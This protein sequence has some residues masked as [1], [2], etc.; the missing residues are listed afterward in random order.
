MK[1]VLAGL[2]AL[3]V[4]AV[5]A[6]TFAL[7]EVEDASAQAAFVLNSGR[8]GLTCTLSGSYSGSGHATFVLNNGGQILFSC[9]GSY[10]EAPPPSAVV[11]SATGPF[12][13]AC[14][15]V[16]DPAGGFHASCHN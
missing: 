8:D 2:L 7:V 9:N 11:T 16:I 5:A 3:S 13:T 1:K 12:G 15:L 6:G 10:A 4:F 14:Q